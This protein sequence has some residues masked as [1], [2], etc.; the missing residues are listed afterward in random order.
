MLQHITLP[1]DQKAISEVGVFSGYGAAFGNVDLGRDRI[2]K[3]AF[4]KSIE[5]VKKGDR[6]IKMLWQHQRH[7]PIGTYEKVAEDD[8]GLVVEGKLVLGVQQ[9]SEAHALMKANALDGLSIGVRVKR[10]DIDKEEMVRNLY[11][12][13][14]F[15]VSPVTFPM[16][17]DAKIMNVKSVRDFEE[18]LTRDAGF[19]RKQALTIINHGYKALDDMRDAVDD[20]LAEAIQ[21]NI[22]TLNRR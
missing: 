2:H 4:E 6:R 10:Y 14:L 15:E 5:L 20:G 8:V 21:R 18:W 9:A 3:G 13:D 1:F 17:T 11:E 16:N 7:N 19:T 12:L 22:H